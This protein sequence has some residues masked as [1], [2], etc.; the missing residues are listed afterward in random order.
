MSWLDESSTKAKLQ[1]PFFFICFKILL[2]ECVHSY[3]SLILYIVFQ[4]YAILSAAFIIIYF[5][6]ITDNFTKYSSNC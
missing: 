4:V 5:N 3:F 2:S 6:E 1:N